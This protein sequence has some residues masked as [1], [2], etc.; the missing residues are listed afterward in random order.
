MHEV[1]VKR[2]V[3]DEQ[4]VGQATHLLLRLKNFYGH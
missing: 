2:E 4:L 1:Q 3:Q